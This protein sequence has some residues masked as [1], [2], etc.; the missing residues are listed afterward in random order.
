MR[1]YFAK[2]KTDKKISDLGTTLSWRLTLPQ[3]QVYSA[4]TRSCR[5][6]K[7]N[8]CGFSMLLT[9]HKT[10]MSFHKHSPKVVFFFFFL[11]WSAHNCNKHHVCGVKGWGM[12]QEEK[13]RS[14]RKVGRSKESRALKKIYISKIT[15]LEANSEF[16][17]RVL[18]TALYHNES[19]SMGQMYTLKP[20]MERTGQEKTGKSQPFVHPCQL[21]FKKRTKKKTT[22]N[23]NIS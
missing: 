20:Q 10:D 6:E 23:E 9:K 21:F 12:C 2:T 19:S 16:Q 8:R 14:W 18:V 15:K 7:Y 17:Y 22:K 3:L 1:D 4:L 11:S 5:Q 13:A